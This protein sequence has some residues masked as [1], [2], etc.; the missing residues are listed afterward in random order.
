M[1]LAGWQL[2]VAEKAGAA[3]HDGVAAAGAGGALVA[4]HDLLGG[5]LQQPLDLRLGIPHGLFCGA[6][7]SSDG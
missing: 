3:S 5:F 7:H 6:L 1:S 2:S 4:A